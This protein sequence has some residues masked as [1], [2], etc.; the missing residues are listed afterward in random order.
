MAHILPAAIFLLGVAFC[1]VASSATYFVAVD[2]KDTNSGAER[3]PWATLEHAS[4]QVRPG[5]VVKVKPGVYQQI[6]LVRNCEGTP[7]QPITFEADG[8]VTIDGSRR[9]S[10]WND[11]GGGCYSTAVGKEEVCRVWA[12]DRLLCGPNYRE[13]FSPPAKPARETL[14]RGQCVQEDRRLYVRLFDG[15]N[16]NRITMRASA[17]DCVRLYATAY[18]VWRGIGAAWGVKAYILGSACAHNLIVDAELHH[19]ENGILEGSGCHDNTFQ[20]LDMHDI[21]LTKFDHGIYTDALRTKIFGCHFHRISGTG[22]HAYPTPSQGWYDGNIFSDPLPTYYPQHFVGRQPPDPTASYTAMICCGAGGHQVTNNLIYG[23]FDHGMAIASGNNHVANNTIVLQD[24]AGMFVDST[25][26]E[27]RLHNNI[28]QTSGLYMFGDLPA[29]LDFNGYWGGKGWQSGATT[30]ATRADL[31]KVDK[32]IHGLVANP[33]F[34][35]AAN[36]N[37]RLAPES[38][39]RGAGSPAAAPPADLLGVCR[40]LDGKVSLGAYEQ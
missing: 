29:E 15:S 22:I 14:V 37:F 11:E 27:S 4:Q 30:Y 38:P 21:G 26:G 28:I 9:M 23:P 24:G 36:G 12:G 13:P 20:R 31:R 8:S 5:D 6:N 17:G 39:M 25:H 16:P 1:S 2:G 7:S 18:T 40:P 34:V 33:R 35:D 10:N 19:L 3:K 32:E